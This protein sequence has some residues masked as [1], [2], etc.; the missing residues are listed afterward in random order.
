MLCL[1]VASPDG[2]CLAPSG[3]GN[4]WRASTCVL[5]GFSAA[6]LLAHVINLY[7]YYTS[8]VSPEPQPDL[9]QKSKDTDDADGES[10][11]DDDDD[12]EPKPA[13][14]TA[15]QNIEDDDEAEAEAQDP[16]TADVLAVCYLSMPGL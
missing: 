14:K 7:Q 8:T 9:D 12:E 2:P 16:V 10:S 15:L 3:S 13:S 6:F 5:G 11:D 4:E 1:R